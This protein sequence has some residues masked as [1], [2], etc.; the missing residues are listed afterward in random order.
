MKYSI[1]SY[2][3]SSPVYVIPMET[4]LT[5]VIF[6]IH[7]KIMLILLNGRQFYPFHIFHF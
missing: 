1:L 2:A 5:L 4:F 6:F 3:F 7:H